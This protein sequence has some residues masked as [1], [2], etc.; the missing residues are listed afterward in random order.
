M[1]NRIYHKPVKRI[2]V[3]WLLAGLIN[4][5]LYKPEPKLPT[6]DKGMPLV[7]FFKRVIKWVRGS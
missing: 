5:A 4:R 7:R 6:I 1:S 2:E 3:N